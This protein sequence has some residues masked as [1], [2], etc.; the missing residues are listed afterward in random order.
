MQRPLAPSS[1]PRTTCRAAARAAL[2]YAAQLHEAL[3]ALAGDPEA[4]VRAALAAALCGV[5]RQLGSEHC[6]QFLKRCARGP[7]AVAVPCPL[8]S[9]WVLA[10]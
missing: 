9:V 3:A 1:M 10:L 6:A 8:H 5:A 7:A 2:R 4:E